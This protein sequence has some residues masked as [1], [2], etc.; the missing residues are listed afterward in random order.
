[1]VSL[2]D[3]DHNCVVTWMAQYIYQLFEIFFIFLMESCLVKTLSH[4]EAVVKLAL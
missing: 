2:P 4:F 3:F 1:M